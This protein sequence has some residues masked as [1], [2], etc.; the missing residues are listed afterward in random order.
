MATFLGSDDAARFVARDPRAYAPRMG[1]LVC[2]SRSNDVREFVALRRGPY[3]CDL[4]V[5]SGIGAIEVIG[6]NVGDA[7]ALARLEVDGR[8]VL[9]PRSELPWVAVLEQRDTR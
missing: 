5:A 9:M 6:G 1:D 7:V 3:H 4:V 8:G 2:A